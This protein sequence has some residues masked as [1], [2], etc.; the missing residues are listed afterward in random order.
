VVS[1]LAQAAGA[2]LDDRSAR[3]L[4]NEAFDQARQTLSR[5]FENCA[6]GRFPPRYET[7]LA[8]ESEDCLDLSGHAAGRRRH[9]QGAFAFPRDGRHLPALPIVLP[10]HPFPFLVHP[11]GTAAAT[12]EL[13]AFLDSDPEVSSLRDQGIWTEFHDRAALFTPYFRMP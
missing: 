1:L 4:V 6:R 2:S 13:E 7:P 12:A 9:A 5:Y 11:S 8:C 10:D 3:D